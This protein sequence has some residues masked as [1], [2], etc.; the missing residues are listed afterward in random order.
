MPIRTYFRMRKIDES[1]YWFVWIK[2]LDTLTAVLGFVAIFLG[3]VGVVLVIGHVIDWLRTGLWS[4][5]TVFD[6]LRGS[7]PPG[8]H[9]W[10]TQP[11]NWLGLWKIVSVV[12]S[13]SAWWVYILLAGPFFYGA[14]AVDKASGRL[15]REK[16]TVPQGIEQ[17]EEK[18]EL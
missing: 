9:Q 17:L 2:I 1:W 18:G 10:I 7:L 13:W 8:V 16:A 4:P 12:F 5:P 15:S 11:D 3:F 14:R 6:E